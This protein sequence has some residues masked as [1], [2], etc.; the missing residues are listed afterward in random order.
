MVKGNGMMKIAI[1]DDEPAAVQYL[2]FMLKKT[3][4]SYEICCA[5]TNSTQAYFKIIEERP[6]IIF[7]DIS[8][9]V[10]N[11]LD[12]AEKILEEY[13][14]RI[15]LL[16]SYEDFEFAKR[17]VKL[18]VSDYLLKNELN[19]KM[20]TE[21]LTNASADLESEKR[22]RHVLLENNLRSFLL[23]KQMTGTLTYTNKPQQRYALL[24]FYRPIEISLT[25]SQR[26]RPVSQELDCYQMQKVSCP[27]G[28][29]CHGFVQMNDDSYAAVIFMNNRI[30][31]DWRKLYQI[32]DAMLDRIR[33]QYSGW[34]CMQSKILDNFSDLTAAWQEACETSGFMYMYPNQDIFSPDDF[35]EVRKRNRLEDDTQEAGRLMNVLVTCLDE[36]MHENAVRTAEELFAVCR[37]SFRI[38][39]YEEYMREIYRTI[40]ARAS[41]KKL[42]ADIFS[43]AE[44]YLNTENLERALLNC[45]E[46]YF[47]ELQRKR[48]NQYS[49]HIIR[50]VDFI[51]KNYGRDISVSDIAEACG[52]SE[53]H[54][55]RLFNLEL[56]TNVIDY[57]TDYRIRK[58]KQYIRET[59]ESLTEIWKKTGFSSAQYF[60]YLFKKK[61][62]I[63]PRDYLKN[64]RGVK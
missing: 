24:V 59:D 43:V 34:K 52:V 20:L 28:M 32:S 14:A 38:W 42:N 18:G 16:T 31:A 60:S 10:M 13:E 8:M 35:I 27:D 4:L 51:R 55:R 23:D 61:E 47:G 5:E 2:E 22:E 11:G 33:E 29:S 62:G 48:E 46:I 53:G 25:Q 12:L 57:L 63:L 6:D 17:G 37:K 7:L 26:M 45:L 54:L 56:Q 41:R 40:C 39:K 15:Y 1:V 9:P 21:L 64:V 49:E 58:V 19:E 3:G 50:A 44:S 30:N 36:D